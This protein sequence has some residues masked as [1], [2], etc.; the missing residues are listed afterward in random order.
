MN[1]SLCVSG[2]NIVSRK[3]AKE[4]N[5][6]DFSNR[7]KGPF[8]Y[9]NLYLAALIIPIVVMIPALILNFSFFLLAILL[10]L[11]GLLLPRFFVVFS[12]IACM[13]CAAKK[14]CPNAKVMGIG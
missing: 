14:L 6:E 2:L 7:A 4:G 3:I 8:C 13:H 12:K 9:N 10:V 5:P 1:N 11:V